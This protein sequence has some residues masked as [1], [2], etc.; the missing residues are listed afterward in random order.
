MSHKVY[1]SLR[2]PEL[3]LVLSKFKSF[4]LIIELTLK[5][6]L[7]FTLFSHCPYNFSNLKVVLVSVG[8]VLIFFLVAGIVLC[9][10]F[11]IRIIL[12]IH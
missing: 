12:I 10:G 3:K 6:K 7:I 1:S 4:L 2:Y 8:I 11:K 9:S 5:K